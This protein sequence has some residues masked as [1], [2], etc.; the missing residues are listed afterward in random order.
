MSHDDSCQ[1]GVFLLVV[2][3]VY[4]LVTLIC[5]NPLYS[6]IYRLDTIRDLQEIQ[7]RARVFRVLLIVFFPL[8][9]IV[10]PVVLSDVFLSCELFDYAIFCFDVVVSLFFLWWICRISWCLRQIEWEMSKRRVPQDDVELELNSI[11]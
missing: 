8:F 11:A 9:L 10:A 5:G 2:E 6:T 1:L 7:K 4:V 3:V